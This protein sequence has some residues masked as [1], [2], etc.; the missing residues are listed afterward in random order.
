MTFSSSS[1][2]SLVASSASTTAAVS[3]HW[4]RKPSWG[5][6]SW[7]PSPASVIGPSPPSH[8]A[9]ISSRKT[10]WRKTWTEPV[11]RKSWRKLAD[12]LAR[13]RE[14]TLHS[15]ERRGS[16]ISRSWRDSEHCSWRHSWSHLGR[17]STASAAPSSSIIP[18]PVMHGT[19]PLFPSL[20]LWPVG[21]RLNVLSGS[22]NEL[23]GLHTRLLSL[24][25]KLG[26]VL[27]GNREA[28][29]QHFFFLFLVFLNGL[30]FF[31]AHF[32]H[33]CFGFFNS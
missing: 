14:E 15:R 33:H 6:S 29:S 13:S 25:W 8:R 4:W 24:G 1:S 16:E 20:L 22:W 28:C 10:S 32:S 3:N 21:S 12:V 17:A 27:D 5:E 19:F 11:G 7:K 18:S 23:L 31:H 30:F 26:L 2:P 9:G